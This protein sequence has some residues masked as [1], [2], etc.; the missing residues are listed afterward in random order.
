VVP[1]GARSYHNIDLIHP[2]AKG[3]KAIAERLAQA[4]AAQ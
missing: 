1:M 3:S 4:M 2:S